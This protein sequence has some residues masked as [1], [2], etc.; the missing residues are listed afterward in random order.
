MQGTNTSKQKYREAIN[1]YSES[2]LSIKDICEQTGVGFSAFSSYLSKHHRD[3]II[4]RHNL[5]GFTNVR[6]RGKKGQTTASHYI[7][8]NAIAACD[9][10][11]YVEYNI[12]QIARIFN[13]NCSS[14]ANQLRKHYPEIVPRREKERKRLGINVNL[15]YGPRQCSKE[16]YARATEMLRSSDM[17][18]E[19]IAN[20]CNVS[21]TGLREHIAAYYPEIILQRERKR[22]QATGQKAKGMRNGCWSMHTPNKSS[23]E[24]YEKALELYRTTSKDITEI[25]RITQ[26]SLGGFRYHLKTWYPELIVERRGFNSGIDLEQ[27]KRYKKS[28]AEKYEAAIERMKTSDLPTSKIAAEFSLNPE[29]FRMY[30]KEHHPELVSVR[31]MTKTSNGKT[32]SFRSAEKYA[33]AVHLYETTPEPLKSIAKRLGITYNS[34]GAYIRR[35]HP[36]AKEKHKSCINNER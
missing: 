17:T 28:T 29:I 24:K 13:V 11:E 5:T 1:L 26:V 23:I 36:E 6:L 31:G 15:K 18:L 3:L 22:I 25:V 32:V 10:M 30:L 8:K 19:E 14:L 4:K 16:G 21:Y 20:S 7:Y 12:S 2:G 34:I 27:T 33:K 9:S 35:N